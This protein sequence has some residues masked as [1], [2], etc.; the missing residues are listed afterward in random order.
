MSPRSHCAVLSYKP[1]SDTCIQANGR[2]LLRNILLLSTA[3]L[4]TAASAVAAS[5]DVRSAPKTKAWVEIPALRWNKTSKAK[6]VTVDGNPSAANSRNDTTQN[7]YTGGRPELGVLFDSY[8]LVVSPT[9]FL[10][11]WVFDENLSLGLCL[12][13]ENEAARTEDLFS[14]RI[15]DADKSSKRLGPYV[16]YDTNLA[17]AWDAS[18]YANVSL[19]PYTEKADNTDAT[20]K[21]YKLDESSTTAYAAILEMKAV[22]HAT[23]R[24]DLRAGPGIFWRTSTYQFAVENGETNGTT[25]KSQYK[26]THRFTNV[27]LD[28]LSMR[29]FL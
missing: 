6:S 19:A 1:F 3:T 23:P 28:L 2:P 24:L 12:F 22:Y 21:T 4:F 8:R 11:G 14:S 29:L 16:N 10:A 20:G 18:V 17:G 13:I 25:T 5:V 7:A 27:Y 26:Q 9:E 15:D